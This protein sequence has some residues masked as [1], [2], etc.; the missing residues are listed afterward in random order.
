MYLNIAAFI[1][2]FCILPG[3]YGMAGGQ[4]LHNFISSGFLTLGRGHL[5]AQHSVDDSGQ[6]SWQG[7][8]DM[9]L[10]YGTFSH[11]RRWS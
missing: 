3:H 7:D 10:S 9:P 6:M 2:H 8:V 11:T 5:K 4:D 1:L